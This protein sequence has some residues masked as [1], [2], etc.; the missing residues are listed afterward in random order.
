M[1]EADV[2]LFP[3]LRDGGGAVVL[4]AMASGT[5]VICLDSGGPGFHVRPEWGIKVAAKDPDSAVRDM[6]EAL[7]RLYL[8]QGMRTRMGRTAKARVL[9]FYVWDKL[10]DRLSGIYS[11]CLDLDADRLLYGEE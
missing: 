7:E 10:G 8:D 6:A 3:S 2:F 9:E 11:K 4:E 5:P 1:A